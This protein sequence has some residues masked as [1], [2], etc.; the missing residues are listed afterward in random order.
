MANKVTTLERLE[1]QASMNRS[2]RCKQGILLVFIHAPKRGPGVFEALP[3]AIVFHAQETTLPRTM[4][5]NVISKISTVG[6]ECPDH[7]VIL[8]SP[9]KRLI[10]AEQRAK[11]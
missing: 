4:L 8:P 5:R 2:L 3:T 11:R 9:F 10:G 7:M 1:R 6:G